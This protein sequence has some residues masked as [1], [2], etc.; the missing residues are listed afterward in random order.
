MTDPSA[1]VDEIRTWLRE[2]PE[3]AALRVSDLDHAHNTEPPALV[4]GPP[5]W[6]YD[7]PG[8]DPVNYALSVAVVVADDQ[9]AVGRLLEL[10]PAVATALDVPAAVVVLRAR[11]GSFPLGGKELPAYLIDIEVSS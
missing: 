7:T 2:R 8:A 4:V 11:P 10:T 5:S 9:R 1:L 6:E 3:L